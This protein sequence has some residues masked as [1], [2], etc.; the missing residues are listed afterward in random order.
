M[1]LSNRSTPL[2]RE[3]GK[4]KGGH[5]AECGGQSPS[6]GRSPRRQGEPLK[7]PRGK[8]KAKAKV[9]ERPKARQRPQMLRCAEG[10]GPSEGWVTDLEQDTPEGEDTNEEGCWTEEDDET[11]QLGY[12]GSEFCLVSSPRGLRD[13]FSEGWMDRGDP[14][15]AKPPAMLHASWVPLTSVARFSDLCGTMTTT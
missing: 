10:L 2:Q 3:R 7:S 6:R 4:E 14:Q 11:L 5:I 1:H 8:A 13:A 12:L 9:E 15:I